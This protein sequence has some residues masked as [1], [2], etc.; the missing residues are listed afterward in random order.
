MATTDCGSG[1]NSQSLIEHYSNGNL[2]LGCDI[3]GAKE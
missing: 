1:F 3:G 2:Q